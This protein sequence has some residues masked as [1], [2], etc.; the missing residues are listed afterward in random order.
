M[1]AGHLAVVAQ[2]G[3]FCDH[4][5]MHRAAPRAK[6]ISAPAHKGLPPNWSHRSGQGEPETPRKCL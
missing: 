3:Y 5:T 4:L 6:R 1:L 2:E